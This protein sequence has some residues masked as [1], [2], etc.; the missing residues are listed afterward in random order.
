[1]LSKGVHEALTDFHWLAKDVENRPT[2]IYELVPLRPNVDGYR[3]ASSYMC[4][5]MA[6]PRPTAIPRILPPQPSTA[7]PSPNP[8][9]DHPIVWRTPFPKDIVDSLVS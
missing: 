5:G 4:G 3:N 1:M 9:V 7:Q 8:N 6:L 2:H